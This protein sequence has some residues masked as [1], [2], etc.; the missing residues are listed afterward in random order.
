[1]TAPPWARAVITAALP[2]RRHRVRHRSAAWSRW[3][4]CGRDP[5]GVAVDGYLLSVHEDPCA[6]PGGHRRLGCRTRA[7]RSLRANRSRRSRRPRRPPAGRATSRSGS[8][9]IQYVAAAQRAELP[10][11]SDHPYR[12]G[13][14]SAARGNAG[15]QR[16]FRGR[17]GST[18]L[19]VASMGTRASSRR[20]AARSRAVVRIRSASVAAR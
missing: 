10:R 12:S 4:L 7:R 3:M 17:V 14:P 11:L 20:R 18:R 9:G 16:A 8:R 13:G 1:M 2:E 5:A 6:A 19:A 15:H